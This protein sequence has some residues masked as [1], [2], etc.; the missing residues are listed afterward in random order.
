LTSL[1]GAQPMPENVETTAEEVLE[2]V[3]P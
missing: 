3:E 2:G 1:T